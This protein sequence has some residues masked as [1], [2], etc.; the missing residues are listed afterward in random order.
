MDRYALWEVVPTEI[1][2]CLQSRVAQEIGHVRSLGL[3]QLTAHA[4]VTVVEIE[5]F[6]SMK[7]HVGDL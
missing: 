7:K 2:N 5:A 4:T 3:V 1:P 6:V